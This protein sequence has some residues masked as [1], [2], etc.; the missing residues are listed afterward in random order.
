MQSGSNSVTSSSVSPSQEK[1]RE[2]R[3]KHVEADQKQ[4]DRKL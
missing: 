3:S 4:E 1:A 2:R